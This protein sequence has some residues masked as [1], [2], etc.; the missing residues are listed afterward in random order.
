[1]ARRRQV[2]KALWG[3]AATVAVVAGLLYAAIGH[4]PSFYPP[5]EASTPQRRQQA[6]NFVQ[7][8]LQLRNDAVNEERWEAVFTQDEVNAWLAEDLKSQFPDLLPESIR[9]PRIVFEADRATIAL[10]YEEGWIRG[11]LWAV[12][13][14]GTGA[15]NAV[16][17]EVE[18]L[19][20]GMLPLP[21]VLLIDWIKASPALPLSWTRRDGHVV[22]VLRLEP[23]RRGRTLRIDDV[24]FTEG[25]M[26]VLGHSETEMTAFREPAADPV[27]RIPQQSL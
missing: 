16:E 12:V 13:R 18:T 7:H 10:T 4:R 19:R 11:V 27:L 5:S 20:L 15:E 25:R 3:A 17:L 23:R 14:V 6:A 1:M 24:R 22:A 8:S 21:D 26:R 2:G 9:E